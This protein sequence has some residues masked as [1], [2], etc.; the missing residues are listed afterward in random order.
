MT[1]EYKRGIRDILKQLGIWTQLSEEEKVR[2]RNCQNE[3]Q[4][5]QMQVTFRHKYL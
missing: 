5:Q 2:F 1:R 3:I 4:L